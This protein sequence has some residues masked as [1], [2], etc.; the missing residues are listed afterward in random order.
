MAWVVDE[1]GRDESEARM[2]DGRSQGAGVG[3]GSATRLRVRRCLAGLIALA[4]VLLATDTADARDR[5]PAPIR[6][7]LTR[8]SDWRGV[9]DVLG[10]PGR[11]VDR[12]AYGVGFPRADL[13]VV[14]QG[15]RVAAIGSFVSFIRYPDRRTMMMGELAVTEREVRKV[16]DVLVA[17]GLT[18]TSLHEH[19]PAHSPAMWWLHFHGMGRDPLAL[20]R[21]LRAVLDVTGTPHVRG[22]PHDVPLALDGPAV[23]RALG[24]EGRAQGKVYKVTYARKET[25]ADHDRVL[26]R[27]TGSTSALI[28]QPLG[29]DK[30]L[31]NGDIAVTARE[32]PAVVKALRR[33]KID[34]VAFH[35]HMLTDQPRLF[36]FHLWAV[37]DPVRLAGHL[38][39]AIRHT[40]SAP[41]K[42]S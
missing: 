25:V 16:H 42:P 27:M 34:I 37:G 22:T 9:A 23:D 35:S 20:A 10:H 33:G 15:Q 29:R 6:P 24:A 3:A 11:V 40:N 32:V 4:S 39:A 1:T 31:L 7:S 5:H 30:A 8:E 21:A 17:R 2:V 12:R 41:A 26:P 14:C 19:L 36:Y 18:Q 13:K 28:F 38:R